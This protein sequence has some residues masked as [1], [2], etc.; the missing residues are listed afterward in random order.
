ME[1]YS[2]STRKTLLI[3][4][5]VLIPTILISVFIGIKIGERRVYT[6]ILNAMAEPEI[7][8]E[9]YES[10]ILPTEEMTPESTKVENL[11]D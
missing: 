2:A 7:P 5:L 1:N 9:G 11:A 8:E 4:I 10:V 3:S 6:E